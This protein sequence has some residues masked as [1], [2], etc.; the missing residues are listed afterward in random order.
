MVR[1]RPALS[2]IL[3]AR[4]NKERISTKSWIFVEAYG[5]DAITLP[6]QQQPGQ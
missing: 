4:E 2:F 5:V 3:H 6:P 1:D